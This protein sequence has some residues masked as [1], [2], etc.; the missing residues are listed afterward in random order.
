MI[1]ER[2]DKL[3]K[4]LRWTARILAGLSAGLILTIFIGEGIDD[5]IEPLFHLTVREKL[6]FVAFGTVWVGL[7]LG[8]KS[9][10]WGGILIL[11]GTIAFHLL[12]YAFSGNFPRGPFFLIFAS[13]GVLFLLYA[14]LIRKADCR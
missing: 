12:D 9:E 6:M 2:N 8:W 10:L 11:G 4:A 1:N 3:I 14:W 5:G 13:P 7:I